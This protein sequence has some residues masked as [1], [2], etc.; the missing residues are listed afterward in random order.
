MHLYMYIRKQF[1]KAPEESLYVQFLTINAIS[2]SNENLIFLGDI[3]SNE[4]LHH[5]DRINEYWRCCC[6]N[7]NQF[8]NNSGLPNLRKE[9]PAL[10]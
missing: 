7:Y 6:F 2:K 3:Q 5:S 9:S 4:E 1:S 10:T 8:N